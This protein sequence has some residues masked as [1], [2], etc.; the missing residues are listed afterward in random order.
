M[1]LTRGHGQDYIN[2]NKIYNSNQSGYMQWIRPLEDKIFELTSEA[3]DTWNNPAPT[4]NQIRNLYEEIDRTV[5]MI[6]GEH[7]YS[8]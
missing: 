6:Y 3:M 5:V 8:F 7:G 2:I 1:P 4:S